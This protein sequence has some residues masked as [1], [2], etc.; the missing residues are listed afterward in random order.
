MKFWHSVD[1]LPEY[2]EGNFNGHRWGATVKRSPD[3]KR[4]WLSAQ[5]LSGSDIVS[6]NPY[7]L[8]DGRNA[9]ESCGTSSEKVVAF[10]LGREVTI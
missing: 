8:D 1:M 2:S 9:L 10:V 6:F 3:R 5:G 7:G 4:I